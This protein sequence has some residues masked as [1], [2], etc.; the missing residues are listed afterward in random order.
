[1]DGIDRRVSEW[2]GEVWLRCYNAVKVKV[3][4]DK[5]THPGG[6]R[7]RGPSTTRLAARQRGATPETWFS[8]GCIFMGRVERKGAWPSLDWHWLPLHMKNHQRQESRHTER[9]ALVLRWSP[10]PFRLQPSHT[11]EISDR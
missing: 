7:T 6:C 2:V 10:D 9:A 3:A 8:V 1:M 11:D 5:K 4:K